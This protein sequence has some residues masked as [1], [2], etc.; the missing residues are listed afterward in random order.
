MAGYSAAIAGPQNVGEF[1]EREAELKSPLC[2]LNPLDRGLREEAISSA[3]PLRYRKNADPFVVA[4]RVRADAGKAGEF[5]RAQS[6]SSHTRSMH[7]RIGSRVK[8]FFVGGR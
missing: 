7:P 8:L 5:S 2:K 1:I 4:E 6:R 3:R